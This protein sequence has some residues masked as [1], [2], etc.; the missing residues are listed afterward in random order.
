MLPFDGGPAQQAVRT[1]TVQVLAPGRV[2]ARSTPDQSTVLAPMTERGEVIGLLD[3]VFHKNPTLKC[4]PRSPGSRTY[5]R[6]WSS[7]TGAHTVYESGQ[8]SRPSACLRRSRSASSRPPHLRGSCLHPFGIAEPAAEIAGDTFDFSL[9]RDMLAP[10][11]DRRHG[12]R[13]GC[14]ADGQPVRGGL[15]G[16]RRQGATVLDRRRPRTRPWRNM[17]SESP[18]TTSSLA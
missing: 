6:S 2:T 1:Q 14:R 4:W 12:T 9:A 10:V 15:L 18:R 17:P 7:R 8:R 11:D 16:A 13:S 5:S 3:S